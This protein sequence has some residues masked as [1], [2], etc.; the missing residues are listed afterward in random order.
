M[1]KRMWP[2]PF[3]HATA[4]ATITPWHGMFLENSIYYPI[5]RYQV[6]RIPVSCEWE[7]GGEES[8]CAVPI[9]SRYAYL[10][11]EGS[12]TLGRSTTTL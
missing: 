11:G 4:E 2:R 6:H 8:Y 9:P 12:C 7:K 10:E 1:I 5:C 3:P